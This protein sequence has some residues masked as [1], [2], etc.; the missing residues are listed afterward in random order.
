MEI[1]S[2]LTIFVSLSLQQMS[3]YIRLFVSCVN[4]AEFIIKCNPN[5][6]IVEFGSLLHQK[7][8]NVFPVTPIKKIK[9]SKLNTEIV[10]TDLTDLSNDDHIKV[11]YENDEQSVDSLQKSKL[12]SN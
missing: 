3:N 2:K 5:I 1:P 12:L 4:T 10:V 11:L 6:S 9:F 7:F 8:K